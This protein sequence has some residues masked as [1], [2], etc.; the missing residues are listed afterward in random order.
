MKQGME[1]EDNQISDDEW[2]DIIKAGEIDQ[3]ERGKSRVSI[4]NNPDAMD[5]TVFRLSQNQSVEEYLDV[6]DAKIVFLGKY[7][8]PDDLDEEELKDYENLNLDCLFEVLLEFKEDKLK[9]TSVDIWDVIT[10]FPGNGLVLGW[11]LFNFSESESGLKCIIH[12]FRE[13]D[14]VANLP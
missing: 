9:K 2:F 11:E 5:C 4:L 14:S 6:G 13:V 10:V 7:L 3:V 8:V 12:R 1:D